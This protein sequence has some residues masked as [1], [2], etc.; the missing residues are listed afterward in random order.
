MLCA[1]ICSL[2]RSSLVKLILWCDDAYFAQTHCISSSVRH[3]NVPVWCVSIPVKQWLISSAL[4]LRLIMNQGFYQSLSRSLSLSVSVDQVP[5]TVLDWHGFDDPLFIWG[6]IGRFIDSENRP[7][8]NSLWDWTIFYRINGLTISLLLDV[9]YVNIMSSGLFVS[10]IHLYLPLQ[11]YIC[12]KSHYFS[13]W[14]HE[15][16]VNYDSVCYILW[17]SSRSYNTRKNISVSIPAHLSDSC[18]V[19]AWGELNSAVFAHRRNCPWAVNFMSL[20]ILEQQQ[21][22]LRLLA[23]QE[24]I[25][26]NP[27]KAADRENYPLQ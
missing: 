6:T 5:A 8:I 19:G 10:C 26:Q 1:W 7:S 24:Q 16:D 3:S 18:S 2:H 15:Q 14:C 22:W 27:S 21:D 12:S 25:F 4:Q 23:S 13:H 20:I 9:I 17:V 11:W